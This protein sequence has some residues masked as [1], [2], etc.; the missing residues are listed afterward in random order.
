M[1][2]SLHRY[3]NPNPLKKKT[4][5]C[6]FRACSVALDLDWD[7]VFQDLCKIGLELKE[8]PNMKPAY[9][10]LLLCHGFEYLSIK[11]KKGSKRPTVNQVAKAT[12]NTSLVIVCRLANHIVTA[13][14]G[15]FWDTW[16]CGDKSLY[17]YWVKGSDADKHKLYTGGL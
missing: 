15:T 6:V 1:P 11:V 10:E 7:S 16:D 5:D 9:N 4:G 2:K 17:G 3:V 14:E 8:P 12:K 13:K